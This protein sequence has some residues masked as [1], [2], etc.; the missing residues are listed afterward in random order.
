MLLGKICGKPC[1]LATHAAATDAAVGG[2]TPCDRA[3]IPA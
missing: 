1:I 3:D 2:V